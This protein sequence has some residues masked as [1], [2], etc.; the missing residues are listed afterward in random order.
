MYSLSIYELKLYFE[1]VLSLHQEYNKNRHFAV[2]QLFIVLLYEFA[3]MFAVNNKG[4]QAKLGRAKDFYN[5]LDRELIV[6]LF[7]TRGLIVHRN[8][9]I[10]EDRLFEFYKTF[11]KRIE[12]LEQFFKNCIESQESALKEVDSFN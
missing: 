5:S 6:N 3:E 1:R 12:N 4:E 10:T 11:E 9:L 2:L 7:R 8:Y